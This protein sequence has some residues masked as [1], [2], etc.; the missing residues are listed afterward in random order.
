MDILKLDDDA[1]LMGRWYKAN[2]THRIDP[3]LIRQ[4]EYCVISIDELN[5]II[6]FAYEYGTSKHSAAPREH[7]KAL[8]LA[9]RDKKERYGLSGSTKVRL[10]RLIAAV[11]TYEHWLSC[12]TDKSHPWYKFGSPLFDWSERESPSELNVVITGKKTVTFDDD[13]EAA[14]QREVDLAV[15]MKLAET[16]SAAAL[17]ELEARHAS[18]RTQVNHM[19]KQV[20]I[21]LESRNVD[22]EHFTIKA[23]CFSV[24]ITVILNICAFVIFYNFFH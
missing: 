11:I 4:R 6:N 18:L 8:R 19:T 10:P 23:M 1:E 12:A 3:T 9:L 15:G 2:A 7:W 21:K 14:I 5:V 16:A 17:M 24:M 22:G 13:M 20:E